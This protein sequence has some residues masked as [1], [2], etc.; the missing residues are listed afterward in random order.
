MTKLPGCGVNFSSLSCDKSQTSLVVEIPGE[1]IY[2]RWVPFGGSVCKGKREV[3]R[4]SLPAFVAF[5][6]PTAQNQ[7]T[8][9]AYFGVACPELLMSYFG[10]AHSSTLHH[11]F[12]FIISSSLLL[13]SVF[14]GALIE[15]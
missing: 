5:H 10:V 4:K 14:W 12:V 11:S 2:H 13:N 6:V 15:L 7:C 3:S 9:V 8:K 1:G